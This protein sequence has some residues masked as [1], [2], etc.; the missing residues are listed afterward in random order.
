MEFTEPVTGGFDLGRAVRESF[1]KQM[2]SE[3]RSELVLEEIS[4]E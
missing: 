2:T 3:L 1:P 4:E